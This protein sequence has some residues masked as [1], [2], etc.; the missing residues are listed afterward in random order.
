MPDTFQVN[1]F[2]SPSEFQILRES[3]QSCW[4]SLWCVRFQPSQKAKKGKNLCENEK[5][6]WAK[7]WQK[8]YQIK[9]KNEQGRKKRE[10]KKKNERKKKE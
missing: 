3:N 2:G 5:K 1:I 8:N 10:R 6:I 9:E 4:K 7:E